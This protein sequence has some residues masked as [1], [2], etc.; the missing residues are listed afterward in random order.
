MPSQTD[1]IAVITG[2]A[3]FIGSHLAEY[4][5]RQ[6]NQVRVVDTFVTGSINNLKHLS[7][8][9]F[10]DVI[11]GDAG[12][13]DLMRRVVAGADE[14]YHLAASV[15]VKHIMENLVQSIENNVAGTASV[16]EVAAE[17]GVRILVTSTSEVYGKTVN[18]P[19][20]EEDDLRMGASWNSRWS[21]ACS[22]ALDEYLAFA[23]W[24]ERQLPVTVVR[25]FNTVGVRQSADYGMVL[26]TF[27]QQAVR[28][29]PLTVFGDGEQTRCFCDVRDVVGALYNL[30]RHPLAVGEVFNIGSTEPISMHDLARRVIAV[31]AS[32]SPVTFV[33]YDQAYRAGFEDTERRIPDISK[34]QA[35]IQFAPKFSL[36][37]IIT[38][39][40]TEI[41]AVSAP[42]SL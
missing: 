33:P 22:K 20:R 21:Y 1:S 24:R 10:L 6:G 40:I 41:A 11:H 12:D 31:Y 29:L 38:S 27:V 3:G 34:I 8:F 7:S 28:G 16:L 18:R 25:L 2:G 42:P 30:M 39:L 19:S 32:S 26:P 14:I 15:G 5:L 23:Y 4:I 17:A 36:D 35:L 9:E 13:K 37:D